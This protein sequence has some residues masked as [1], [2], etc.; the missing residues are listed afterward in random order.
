MGMARVTM[1]Q[2]LTKHELN[3]TSLFPL[4]YNSFYKD[5]NCKLEQFLSVIKIVHIYI[6]SILV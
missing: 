2:N 6:K 4:A 3:E 1:I 5:N